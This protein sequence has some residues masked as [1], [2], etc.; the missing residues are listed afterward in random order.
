MIDQRELRSDSRKAPIWRRWGRMFA[1]RDELGERFAN[2]S[3]LCASVSSTAQ[4]HSDGAQNPLPLTFKIVILRPA[5]C[6]ACSCTRIQGFNDTMKNPGTDASTCRPQAR[7]QYKQLTHRAQTMQYV[8]SAITVS[9]RISIATCGH[10]AG[11]RMYSRGSG[12]Y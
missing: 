5:R 7:A 12:R 6:H 8:S 3:D 4:P 2:Q 9:A 10:A 11:P 1:V